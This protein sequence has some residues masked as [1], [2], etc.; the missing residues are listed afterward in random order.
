MAFP[1]LSRRN[2]RIT[3]EATDEYNC[4]AYA[5]GDESRWWSPHPDYFWPPN[6]L[7]DQ[8]NVQSYIEAFGSVGFVIC[9]D[10]TLEEGY[11]KI[12][13]YVH[14]N[15]TPTHAARQFPNGKWRSKLG[16]LED[17]EHDSEHDVEGTCDYCY[18]DAR[19]YM[20]RPRA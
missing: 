15:G 4:V 17:I 14:P 20:R 11:E 3:S 10:G 5:I 18:G 8:A 19:T 16:V 1:R 7:R 12:A 2:H 13:I 9:A 6:V